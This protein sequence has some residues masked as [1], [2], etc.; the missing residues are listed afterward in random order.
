MVSRC[1]S[2]RW[3]RVTITCRPADGVPHALPIAVVHLSSIPACKDGNRVVETGRSSRRLFRLEKQVFIAQFKVGVELRLP[4]EQSSQFAS[5]NGLA[6]RC[7]V[8]EQTTF[9]AERLQ[10][11]DRHE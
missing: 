7:P 10:H 4:H 3:F 9:F 11:R 1:C 5:S 2:R 8:K 6:R